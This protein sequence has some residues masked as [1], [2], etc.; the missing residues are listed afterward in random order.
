MASSTATLLLGLGNTPGVG[1]GSTD[2]STFLTDYPAMW[3]Y[4]AMG[5]VV[6]KPRPLPLHGGYVSI[7]Y[8]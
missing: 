8:M 5:N 6:N 1:A 2:Q 3:Q 4:D 7:C